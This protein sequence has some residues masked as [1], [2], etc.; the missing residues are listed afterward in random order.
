MWPF[1]D[2]TPASASEPDTSGSTMRTIE[3]H[4]DDT[5]HDRVEKA[6]RYAGFVNPNRLGTVD[7]V[8]FV[9]GEY[10]RLFGPAPSG[11]YLFLVQPFAG[12]LVGGG[13]AVGA[14]LGADF[15]QRMHPTTVLS[16]SP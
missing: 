5:M 2:K 9:L 16:A 3:L 11:V 7:M 1:R 15:H 6:M 10:E 14:D 12:R 13:K 8:A 4:P